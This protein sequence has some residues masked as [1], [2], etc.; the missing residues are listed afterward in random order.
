MPQHKLRSRPG[1]ARAGGENGEG[2]EGW[3][4]GRGNTSPVHGTLQNPFQDVV[5]QCVQPGRGIARRGRYLN[6][7]GQ[8]EA[9]Q[10]GGGIQGQCGEA[11]PVAEADLGLPALSSSKCKSGSVSSQ[12]GG[13]RS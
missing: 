6:D 3:L 2:A 11:K 12:V 13:K 7:S 1:G 10:H 8:L 9:A 4:E 5:A